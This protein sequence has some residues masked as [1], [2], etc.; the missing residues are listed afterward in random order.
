MHS[1]VSLH[2]SF[3]RISQNSSHR[4]DEA[5]RNNRQGII[6]VLLYIDSLAVSIPAFFAD[7][8]ERIGDIERDQN[9]QVS[10]VAQG[11]RSAQ[12]SI[13]AGGAD[14]CSS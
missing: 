9:T 3:L 11:N 8:D 7:L 6:Y 5:M 12:F 4:F 13:H 14:E 1:S 10:P 2:N